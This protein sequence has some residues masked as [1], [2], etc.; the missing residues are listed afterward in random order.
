M[1]GCAWGPLLP[2]GTALPASAGS[3]TDC[4]RRLGSGGR[5][6]C[7]CR[8][9]EAD[10]RRLSRSAG[11]S[12]RDSRCTGS[13]GDLAGGEAAAAAGLA[14]G[15]AALLTS[16]SRCTPA[17]IG[18]RCTSLL[19]RLL[20]LLQLLLLHLL[21]LPPPPTLPPSACCCCSLL[22][23]PESSWNW[24]AWARSAA[25]ATTCGVSITAS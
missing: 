9:R 8:A 12:L 15:G 7:P 23:P 13:G 22:C 11:S 24:A 1:Q 25:A 2:M 17:G 14:V 19:R 3:C 4:A 18:G 16:P 5:P 20:L 6:G 10:S 21:V